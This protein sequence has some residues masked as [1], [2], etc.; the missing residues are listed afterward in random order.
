MKIAYVC[1]EFGPV[2]G[3]GIG[4]YI[5]HVCVAMVNRG[6]QIYLV[7][8]CFTDATISL[9]PAGVELVEPVAT[10]AH[11]LGSFISHSHEYTYRIYDTLVALTE[12]IAIDVIE[13]AE[14]GVEGFAT[15]RAKRL[16]GAFAHTTLI[17]KLHTPASLL[18]EI[19]DDRRL[20]VD[21]LCDYSMEDY[22]VT[23]ADLVTA[24][25]QALGHY[26][27]KRLGRDDIR[28]C[29]YPM[30]LPAAAGGRVFST[31]Q[32]RRV[33]LIGSIQVRKG[34][35]TFIK[36]AVM[37]LHQ[38]PDFVFEIWGAER[39]ALLFGKTYQDIVK[40]LIPDQ[41]SDRI[42]F[43]GSV[44]YQDIPVLFQDSCFCVYPSRWENWAN[45]CLEAMS[46][47]CI[48]LA[49]REGGM[50]E[51]VEEG[52]SGFL[53]DPLE[54]DTIADIVLDYATKPDRLAE[55]SA[56]AY[57]RSTELCDPDK[58]AA[59]IEANYLS[60]IPGKDWLMVE[61]SSAPLVSVIIPYYNQP[62]YIAATITSVQQS[63]YAAIEII[64]VNDGSTTEP[65]KRVFDALENVI[66]VTKENGGLSSARNAGISKANGAFILPLDADD[67]LEPSYI[68]TAVEA[69][70]NNPQ[71]GYVSCHAQNFGELT[72]AYI[73][74]GFVPELM[75]YVNTHG[76]CANVY[77]Q[78]LFAQCGG[79]DEVM[80]SYEDWDFLLSLDEHG[81]EGDVLPLEMFRYRRHFDSMVYATANNQRADLVQYMMI[82]HEQA[83]A[84]HAGKMAIMLARLWKETECNYEWAEQQL[85]NLIVAP[86]V[87]G[88]LAHAS[89]ARLQVY[90][91]I[92]GTYW[93][94]N[95]VYCYY[96][97]DKWVAITLNLPFA[98]QHGCYRLDPIDTAGRVYVKS[99]VATDKHSGKALFKAHAK[100][101]F[102]GCEVTGTATGQVVHPFLEIQATGEDPQI[103][104]PALAPNRPIILTIRFFSTAKQTVSPGTVR[105]SYRRW[106]IAHR[107]LKKLKQLV[108]QVT[109]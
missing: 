53:I 90:S 40:R 80:I 21:S 34:I 89:F 58:T 9:L 64:V 102:R 82:K 3:G 62:E 74:V 56:A 49:S 97:W 103:Q 43:A 27:E 47:G 78:E 66:K 28:Q 25:S 18:Y 36:A 8:D 87:K 69:L 10:P 83:L 35:D 22:C 33:R 1:R 54:P 57:A 68:R 44:S 86:D 39:N 72:N 50:S 52:T 85:K 81:V 109:G 96:E 84:P 95:S 76:K 37:V 67:L 75:P 65:A 6:H 16:L 91:Q 60:T 108:R 63:D 105:A 32:I 100:N 45:V 41:F 24:P 14:F 17:V 19:N 30:D 104:L 46:C 2:T 4:T 20:H 99:I 31:R 38:D 13:F 71:L 7:T 51:M 12:H 88:T 11:R 59:R 26:F 61:A 70:L 15:I 101:H 98:G 55:I 77:R 92:G 42:V 79:Y 5:Y 48:V 23:Y 106:T 93:Q 29:P 107:F 73:P 94:H